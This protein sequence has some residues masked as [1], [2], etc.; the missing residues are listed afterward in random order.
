VGTVGAGCFRRWLVA[1]GQRG[2]RR[3][4]QPSGGQQAQ[5]ALTLA[6]ARRPKL[7]LLDEPLASWIRWPGRT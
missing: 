2:R 7:L 3:A 4:G 5:V 1:G 6:L